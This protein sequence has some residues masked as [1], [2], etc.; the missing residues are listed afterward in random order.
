VRSK[1]IKAVFD[2]FTER[3][4]KAVVFAQRE[5]KALGKDMV[6]TQHLLLGLVAEERSPVGFLG[7]GIT[8]DVARKAVRTIWKDSTYVES[9]SGL[10]TDVPFSMSCKS[11]FEA[12]VAAS[13]NMGCNFIA[14][15]HIAIGLFTADDGSAIQVLQRYH[16]IIYFPLIF[17]EFIDALY[18]IQCRT[19]AS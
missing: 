11:V 17:V 9:G 8:I 3:A 6:F 18:L 19:L 1:P 2:R 16:T 7:S 14:P 4:I 15:E 13:R 12:A 10:A 5:A